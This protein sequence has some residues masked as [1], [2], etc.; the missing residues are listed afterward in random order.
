MTHSAQPSDGDRAELVIDMVHDAP[1][2]DRSPTVL[3]DGPADDLV[4]NTVSGSITAIAGSEPA[5]FPDLGA[6]G[7]RYADVLEVDTL[8][9]DLAHVFRQDPPQASDSERVPSDETSFHILDEDRTDEV[10]DDA[11]GRRRRSEEAIAAPDPARAR[12]SAGFI[13]ERS[14]IQ[15]SNEASEQLDPDDGAYPNGASE[16]FES[17]FREARVNAYEQNKYIRTTDIDIDAIKYRWP[18]LSEMI[19]RYIE[20]TLTREDDHSF[21][22]DS[23]HTT[24]PETTIGELIDFNLAK[25][26]NPLKEHFEKLGRRTR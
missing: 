20:A 8:V 5:A 13:V 21:Y 7:T 6:T 23:F 9:S 12:F 17:A 3:I 2:R 1:P 11:V 22:K 24:D 18:N 14:E 25:S 15:A 10:A 16:Q 26:R 19:E 4:V